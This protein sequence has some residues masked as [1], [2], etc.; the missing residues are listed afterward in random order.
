M[1][2]LNTEVPLYLYKSRVASTAVS[3]IEFLKNL[4]YNVAIEKYLLQLEDTL[5][6]FESY[7]KTLYDAL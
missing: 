3:F 1:G 2:G 7:W 5:D 4:K 6:E